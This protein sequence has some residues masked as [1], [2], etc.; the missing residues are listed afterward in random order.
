M[1]VKRGHAVGLLPITSHRPKVARRG[2]AS[3]EGNVA[4]SSK[5][6]EARNRPVKNWE[7]GEGVRGLKGRLN[8][9]NLMEVLKKRHLV[10]HLY[11]TQ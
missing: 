2:C 6:L 3:G 10:A 11:A 4:V 9:G 7:A 8:G 1:V 5:L